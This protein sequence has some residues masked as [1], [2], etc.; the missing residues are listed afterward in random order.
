M[1]NK[2]TYTLITNNKIAY[3]NANSFD[4]DDNEKPQEYLITSFLEKVN[5]FG[6]KILPSIKIEKN[7]Y[8]NNLYINEKLK[9]QLNNFK[10]IE[11]NKNKILSCINE[12]NKLFNFPKLDEN[13]S[14]EFAKELAMLSLMY[15]FQK[16]LVCISHS[17]AHTY[18][19]EIK[20]SDYIIE[21]LDPMIDNLNEIGTKLFKEYDELLTDD[22]LE[23][24]NIKEIRKFLLPY[25]KRLLFAVNELSNDISYCISPKIDVQ[26]R[27]VNVTSNKVFHLIWHIFV[28]YIVADVSPSKLTFCPSCGSLREQTT[29]SGIKCKK[30]KNKKL[31]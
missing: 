21:K 16:N 19:N 5:K 23:Y 30:C 12:F 18:I 7:N 3:L 20:Q 11:N 25:K 22:F 1:S 6:K 2:A 29:K 24:K 13:E 31:R 26:S 17:Q 4:F 8:R 27:F 10:T 14:I 28:N 15:E 9:K